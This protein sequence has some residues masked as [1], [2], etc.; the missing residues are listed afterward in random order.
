ML[1]PYACRPGRGRTP[2]GEILRGTLSGPA[3]GDGAVERTGG[4]AADRPHAVL[5]EEDRRGAMARADSHGACP[6]RGGGERRHAGAV[7]VA[8]YLASGRGHSPVS[9]QTS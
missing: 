2:P 3:S 7:G 4:T 9:Y 1:T 8:S 6:G 5:G